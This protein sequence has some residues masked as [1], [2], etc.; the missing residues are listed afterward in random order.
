M[1]GIYW[2]NPMCPKKDQR[3]P[4]SAPDPDQLSRITPDSA[5]DQPLAYS[6]QP[7]N[8]KNRGYRLNDSSK[9]IGKF[10][11]DK[12]PGGHKYLQRLCK[13]FSS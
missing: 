9:L 10:S 8:R 1:T 5:T 4:R 2:V 12:F 6:G 13:N 7:T 3:K 11:N